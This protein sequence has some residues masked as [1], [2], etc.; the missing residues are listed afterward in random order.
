MIE[1]K[2]AKSDPKKDPKAESNKDPKKP[3]SSSSGKDGRLEFPAN[4]DVI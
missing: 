1:K 4:Q 2:A 3:S